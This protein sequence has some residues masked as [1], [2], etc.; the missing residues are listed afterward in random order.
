VAQQIP[1]VTEVSFVNALAKAPP[2]GWPA[3]TELS[4]VVPVNNTTA[5]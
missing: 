1:G 5:S 3:N 4:Y 2:S